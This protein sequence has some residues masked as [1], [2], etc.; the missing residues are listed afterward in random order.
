MVENGDNTATTEPVAMIHE[1]QNTITQLNHTIQQLNNK[2]EAQQTTIEKLT[3]LLSEKNQPSVIPQQHDVLMQLRSSTSTPVD[4]N[5]GSQPDRKRPRHNESF[6]SD[7]S[8]LADSESITPPAYKP[9]PLVIKS[10]KAREIMIGLVQGMPNPKPTFTTLSDNFV[11][12]HTE[13]E[14]IFRQVRDTLIKNNV[15]FFTH[16]LR[17]EKLFRV[18]IRGLHPQT[19]TKIIADDLAAN[20]HEAIRITNVTVKK[21]NDPTNSKKTSVPVPIFYVDLKNQRNNQEVDSIRYINHQRVHMEPPNAKRDVIPQCLRCQQLGHT[22]NFCALKERCVKCAGFHPSKKCPIPI[23]RKPKC[24][25]CSGEHTANYRGCPAYLAAYKRRFPKP[26]KAVDRL[27]DTSATAKN[28]SYANAAKS[29][30]TASQPPTST[31]TPPTTKQPSPQPL[32]QPVTP[33]IDLQ[34]HI[35]KIAASLTTL[36]SNFNSFRLEVTSRLGKIES[37]NQNPSTKPATTPIKTLS[38]LATRKKPK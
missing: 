8:N 32:M 2:I 27:R 13:N 25:N 1:L 24:A 18:V 7:A 17:S 38:Q 28:V 20:G 12:I 21:T 22:Q 10:N 9:P 36:A 11:K 29:V 4:L 23:E 5:L 19:E 35:E 26:V 14:N 30:N 34:S 37:T 33:D 16:Q 15:E 3:K 6:D 31:A